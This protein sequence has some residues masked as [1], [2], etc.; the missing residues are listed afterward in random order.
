MN[1]K[2]L[3]ILASSLLL[4]GGAAMAQN[5]PS[6]AATPTQHAMKHHMHGA[7]HMGHHRHGFGHGRMMMAGPSGAVIADLAG[8]ER[9]YRVSGKTRE[10]VPLY[11]DVL[12]KTQ[13]PRVRNYVYRHLARAQMQPGDS[14]AAVATLR[15]SL[16]ENLQ[17]L[18]LR[19]Q[20]I[21]AWKAKHAQS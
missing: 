19:D 21:A 6:P 17:R 20:K 2:S 13:D 9:I 11:Q 15:K 14:A 12:S 18:K 10:L 8:I 3:L 1:R 7:M 4:A 16:D 5:P